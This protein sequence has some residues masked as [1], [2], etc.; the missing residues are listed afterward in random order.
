MDS[1]QTT[2]HILEDFK[3]NV[4]IKLSALWATVMFCYV[5]GDIFSLFVPG[6]IKDLMHGQMGIGP[7]TPS[8]LLVFSIVLAIPA[9]MVF[10]SLT[11][12]PKIN[13]LLNIIM[14]LVYTII[15][16]LTVLAS[17]AP[18]WIFYI[19]LG[20]LEIIITLTIIWHAW[21]WPRS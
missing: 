2:P 12:K 13:R 8:N 6:R 1:N 16:I 9:L 4:K 15:M 3:I 18:W 17:I 14:G 11:L 7:T 10:L 19:F 21:K 20:V 5:Y